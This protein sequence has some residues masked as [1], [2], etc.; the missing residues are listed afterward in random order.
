MKPLFW[1]GIVV[2]ILGVAS[3][4]I[5]IPHHDSSG[6]SV[7]GASMGIRTSHSEKVSPIVSCVLIVLGAGMM[8]GGRSA[9]AS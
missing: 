9:V 5:P 4:A 3:L 2:L 1:A 8:M 7:G 6:I